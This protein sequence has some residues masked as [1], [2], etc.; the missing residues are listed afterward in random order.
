M[1]QPNS[2]DGKKSFYPEDV[3]IHREPAR[4]SAGRES[5]GTV[6]GF[7]SA[8]S[9]PPGGLWRLAENGLTFIDAGLRRTGELLD[10]LSGSPPPTAGDPE[11]GMHH[12]DD[13]TAAWANDA[14]R[15]VRRSWWDPTGWPGAGKDLAQLTT[16]TWSEGLRLQDG[17]ALAVL[18]WRL[19]VAWASLLSQEGLRATA[20]AQAVPPDRL[21]DF[22][23]FVVETFSD[24]DIYFSLRYGQELEDLRRRV[25]RRPH[26]PRTRFELGRTLL[27]CGLFEEAAGELRSAADLAM[28]NAASLRVHALYLALV[29]AHRAGDL[30]TA[31]DLG[32]A[33]LHADPKHLKAKFWL[34]LTADR[35]GGYDDGTPESCR[36]NV[37]DGL[38][39]TPVRYEEV[40]AEI[41]LDKVSGGRG[42]AVADFFGDGNLHVAIS[43]AHAG[44]SLFRNRGDGTFDDLSLGSGLEHCVY[45]FALAAADYDNDGLPDLFVSSL[46]FYDGRGLLFHNEG[47][48]KFRDVTREAGL[49]QWGPAFTAQWLDIDGNGLLDLF[50]AH[51]LGGLFD[52]KVA[53][54]L[55]RNNGDGTFTDI[56]QDAGLHTLWS[57]IGAC[58]G[59][60]TNNGRPDL[61]VSSL[62]RA[63]LFRNQGD[64]TFKDVSREAGIDRS[65]IGSVA[66][67]IDL[68][69]NGWLDIVQATYSRTWEAVYTL[70]QGHGPADGCPSR[71]WRNQGDGTFKDATAEW[72]LTGCWGTMSLGAG[73]VD[74]SG[75]PSLL[76]GNGDPSMDR[77]EGSVLLANDGRRLRNVSRTAGLPLTGKGHGV[78]MADLANDG[79]LHLLVASGGLYPGDLAS[80]EVYRPT[81]AQGRFLNVKL[82]GTRGNRDALGA[83]LSLRVGSRRLERM[84]SGGSGFG[85]A[86]LRQH[87]GL[88]HS[89]QVD[90]LD[91][92]WP[93]GLHQTFDF[94]DDRL[95]IN[96]TIEITEGDAEYRYRTQKVDP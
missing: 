73:D 58:W 65:V 93:S 50:V 18:P 41:G 1:T 55:Y 35:R 67:A 46:G 57:S 33:C 82:V 45:G 52:R 86:P 63:Q 89:D 17:P 69:N 38:H 21:G 20:A 3:P 36:M 78:C 62:G 83:R 42:I 85:W 81:E 37:R 26:A 30:E 79:R 13:L 14:L 51:N 77:T 8:T 70:N 10:R 16:R 19:P 4:K 15:T 88:G 32:L 44:I 48:G 72:G 23:S 96:A 40:S 53:N 2:A 59:D 47:G 74:H 34:R 80:T 84:V 5:V 25:G 71:I 9:S 87:F 60:F 31:T 6:L 64:G 39:A 75:Y 61:F 24:L 95:P 27:K 90:G 22:V 12:A 66:M 76:L 91:I 54:R 29:A 43:G 49:G 11:R 56:T 68:D 28:P 94:T 92:R 7:P